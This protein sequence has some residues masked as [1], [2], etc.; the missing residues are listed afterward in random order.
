[1]PPDVSRTIDTIWRMESARVI[2]A[3]TRT[4]RDVGLAEELAHDALVVALDKWPKEGVPTNPG[5]WLTAVGKRRAIDLLR[6]NKTAA[7]K[8]HLLGDDL[9][10]ELP[11][12][13]DQDDIDDD[14]L[15]LMFTACHPL[16]SKEACVTLS[17][18]LLGGLT[19]EEIARAFLVPE[20]AIA[21]RIVR[22]KR[23]LA[24]VPFEAPRGEE[25][26]QRL[27]SVVEVIYLI[28]NEGY[29]T[30]AGD[31][32]MRQELCEEAMRLGRISRRSRRTNLKSTGS[33]R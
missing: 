18:R 17:L 1:M 7:A 23:R 31:S 11:D 22:A 33:S 29:T 24:G 12:V 14:L 5:A 20:P 15:R 16:L 30:T 26:A 8:H 4:V 3:L 9:V 28:F 27:L 32:W 2:G 21:Q 25:R 10:E 19:T 6:R 13:S